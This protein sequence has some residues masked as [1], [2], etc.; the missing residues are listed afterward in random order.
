MAPLWKGYLHFY[1]EMLDDEV[2]RRT[3]ERLSLQ[4]DDV[5][6]FVAESFD[7][8]LV[9]IAHGLLHPSTRSVSRSCY[10]EEGDVG[11]NEPLGVRGGAGILS[12]RTLD[13]FRTPTACSRR[14]RDCAAS[15]SAPARTTALASAPGL[16]G[17]SRP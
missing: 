4:Q 7:G 5:F 1:R 3:F 10:L 15:T 17:D 14:S 12:A 13:E 6:G 8:K 2:T 11:G 16:P 9:R